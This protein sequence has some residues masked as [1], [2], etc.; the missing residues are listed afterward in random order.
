MKESTVCI[1]QPQAGS[2]IH[3]NELW[4]STGQVGGSRHRGLAGLARRL[5]T[6]HSV[7][8]FATVHDTFSNSFRSCCLLWCP[9][10][11]E[12]KI[13]IAHRSRRS[14][15]GIRIKV[16]NLTAVILAV[17][18][19]RLTDPRGKLCLHRILCSWTP[20]LLQAVD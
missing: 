19:S 20:N 11:K 7:F 5:A 13:L 8:A 3:Y 17:Q 10:P 1:L 6:W 18:S 4:P 14:R 2:S 15:H 9:W 16:P 12:V